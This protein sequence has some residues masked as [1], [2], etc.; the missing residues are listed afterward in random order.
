MP[1]LVNRTAALCAYRC[2][3][4]RSVAVRAAQA[5][6]ELRKACPADIDLS[7]YVRAQPRIRCGPST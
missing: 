1:C 3:A 2:G 5:D 6:N 7:L 4:D